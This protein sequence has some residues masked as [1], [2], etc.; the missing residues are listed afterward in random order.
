LFNKIKYKNQKGLTILEALM[1]TVIVGIGFIAVFQMVN[2][3]V[4]SIHMSGERTKA[5]YLVNMIAEGFIGYRDTIGG[6]TREEQDEVYYEGGKAFLGTETDKKECKKFAE[7]YKDLGVA[8]S[9][10]CGATGSD[11]TKIEVKQCANRETFQRKDDYTAINKTST[12]KDAARNKINK[13]TKVIEEDQVVK[14]R[15]K[16]DFKSVKIFKMCAWDDYTND[17]GETISCDLTNKY[18][19]D[20]SMLIGRIQINLNDG[21]KR[22][23]LYFQA[24]YKIKQS[25]GG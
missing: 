9:T 20:E 19:Y 10:P 7:Y 11:V 23:F 25:N 12:Y 8:G 13:W 2:Y 1:A 4:N 24:D 5:N 14:C 6:I 15:S 22:K 16:K 18:I 21:R 17:L 3:S